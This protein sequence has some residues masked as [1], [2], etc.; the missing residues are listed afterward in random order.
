MCNDS[1][2]FLNHYFSSL[3]DCED[4]VSLFEFQF[5]S[6]AS[7][8]RALDKIVSYPHDDMGHDITQLDFFNCSSE[9]VSAEIGMTSL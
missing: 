3:N 9:F 7:S 2:V 4:R 1:S 5:V 6:A 8:D